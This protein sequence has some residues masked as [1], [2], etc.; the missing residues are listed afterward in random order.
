MAGEP[1]ALVL[2]RTG[3]AL[4]RRRKLP[5]LERPVCTDWMFPWQYPY[6]EVELAHGWG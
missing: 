5:M 4:A 6:L 2:G 1:A 3:I